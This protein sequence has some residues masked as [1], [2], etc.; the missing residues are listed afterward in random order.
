MASFTPNKAP[1]PIKIDNFKGINEGNTGIS[2]EEWSE[3]YNFRVNDTY[4]LEK[5]PGSHIAVNFGSGEVKGLHHGTLKGNKIL[6]VCHGGK[7]Y[8]LNEGE[9]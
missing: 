1:A 9:Y 4:N 3:G 5:R 8:K 6:L 7:V 2:P